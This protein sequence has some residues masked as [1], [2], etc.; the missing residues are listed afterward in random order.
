MSVKNIKLTRTPDEIMNICQH[1]QR[2]FIAYSLVSQ[3]QIFTETIVLQC[4][5]HIDSIRAGCTTFY[6]PGQVSIEW[7][8]V[9][10]PPRDC[11]ATDLPEVGHLGCCYYR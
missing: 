11:I 2:A 4:P 5:R 10:E 3:G 9:L 6:V 7:M 1:S 8:N